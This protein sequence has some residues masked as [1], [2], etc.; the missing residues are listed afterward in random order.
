VH[1]PP[2][3][4]QSRSDRLAQRAPRRMDRFGAHDQHLLAQKRLGRQAEDLGA[5]R[6]VEPLVADQIP[7]HRDDLV[8]RDRMTLRRTGAVHIGNVGDQPV[9]DELLQR[10]V[11]RERIVIVPH[12]ERQVAARARDIEID[13]R[14][15]AAVDRQHRRA[16][17]AGKA[18]R[19]LS[20]GEHHQ[21]LAAMRLHVT[22]DQGGAQRDRHQRLFRLARR[23]REILPQV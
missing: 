5:H 8:E 23:G 14:G 12:Q 7:E 6:I 16:R 19:L 11:A 21:H 1:N 3:V 9:D 17:I 10:L 20:L 13:R 18:Q 22:V 4:E 2:L 15:K